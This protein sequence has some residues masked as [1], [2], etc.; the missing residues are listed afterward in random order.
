MQ[1][2]F[3]ENPKSFS[4]KYLIGDGILWA[5]PKHRRTIERRLK[6]RFGSPYFQMKILQPKKYLSICST[7]GNH[8]EN[9][10]LCPHCYDKVRKE[11]ELIK[12]KIQEKLKLDPV[13][14]DVIVLYDGEKGEQSPEFWQGKRIVEMER[15]RPSWFSKNLMQKSTQPNATT[16]EIN[17]RTKI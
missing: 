13:E 8:H 17:E 14:N 3:Q 10:T 7:C 1:K 5:V 4:L 2:L 6:M 12:E 11:T 15:P 16:K 9:G